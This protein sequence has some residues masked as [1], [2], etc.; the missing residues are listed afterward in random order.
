MRRQ[1]SNAPNPTRKEPPSKANS[2]G[3]CTIG[4]RAEPVSN[5]PEK[6]KVNSK[7]QHVCWLQFRGCRRT[8]LLRF[9]KFAQQLGALAGLLNRTKCFEQRKLIGRSFGF[10]RD[11]VIAVVVPIRRWGFNNSSGSPK[12]VMTHK[13]F[14]G[15]VRAQASLFMLM[16][17]DDLNHHGILHFARQMA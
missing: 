16:S 8:D 15:I 10:A 4:M 9:M 7:P 17:E 11:E 6:S 3:I 5:T 2:F 13:G 14:A 1:T 12:W